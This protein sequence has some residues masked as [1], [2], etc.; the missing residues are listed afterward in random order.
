MPNQSTLSS[1]SFGAPDIIK[2]TGAASS[3]GLA[4]ED[5]NGDKLPEIITTKFLTGNGDATILV[6]NSVQGNFN[7]D[8]QV[9]LKIPGTLVDL[10]IG[11]LDGDRLPEIAATQLLGSSVSIFLNTSAT[12]IQFAAPQSFTVDDHPY[13]LDFGDLDGDGKL[14]IVV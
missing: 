14:D 12:S 10:K 5:L 3:D 11:D 4:I 7:F 8:S 1:I 6:N 13:G 9:T 2:I